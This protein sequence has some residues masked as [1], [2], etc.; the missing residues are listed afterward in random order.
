ME[1]E[2]EK[3]SAADQATTTTIVGAVAIVLA[4]VATIVRFYARFQKRSG[5]WWD[6]W[7]AL[8]AV[9]SAVAAG[10]LILAGNYIPPPIPRP[11]HHKNISPLQA[12]HRLCIHCEGIR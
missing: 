9:L 7:L 3:A 5:L 10:V 11:T 8:V 12:Q 1:T 6:D 4:V 2:S